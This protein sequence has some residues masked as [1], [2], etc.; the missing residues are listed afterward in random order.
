MT[1][2]DIITLV[3]LVI[4]IIAILNEKN[5]QHLLLKFQFGDYLIFIGAFLLINYFVFYES[6]FNRS[7]YL[8][9]LYFSDFGMGNPKNWA[10][11]IA[12]SSLIYFFYK[13]WF[14][15]YPNIRLSRV[16]KFYHDQ[17]EN[18]EISF[19]LDL[20]ERYHKQDI[21][22]YIDRE[23]DYIPD[24]KWYLHK[25]RKPTN[26]EKL[27]NCKNNIIKIGI[28]S[29]WQNRKIY[30]SYILHDILNDPAL[31][32]LAANH[33]PYLF[34]DFISHF[35]ESKRR[36]FP[37]E[38]TNSFLREIINKNNFWLKKELKQS[39]NFDSGQPDNFFSENRI[40][41]SILKDLSVADVNQVWQPFG[42]IACIEIEE[43]RELGYSSKLYQV[44][45]EEQFLWDYKT[46]YAIYFFKVIVTEA[47]VKKYNKSHF[48]LFYYKNIT[49]AILKTF[50]RYP[51]NDI[52][53]TKTNLHAFIEVMFDNLLFWLHISNNTEDDWFYINIIE[54]LGNIIHYTCNSPHYSEK[55]KIQELDRL[56]E[57]YCNLTTNSHSE[58]IRTQIEKILNKPSMLTETNHPYFSL[59][60]QVW[61]DFDKI[62][63]RLH[64]YGVDHEYFKRLKENVI[65]PLQLDP[66]LY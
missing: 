12:I 32:P 54:C 4:A 60:V 35:K 48:W 44:F 53:N 14:S 28:P 3:S 23:K 11:I 38:F 16:V 22:N 29:S 42:D 15:F 18:N 39:A 25:F 13:V 55:R 17:I 64:G 43:E 6:F 30:A 50:E 19:L 51:P 20:I 31:M 57:F 59:M 45:R 26:K 66:D 65:I 37:D 2:S 1:I 36:T 63:H 21:I 34:A 33:R 5:R 58:N 24:P 8:K 62:P 10:Y 27:I 7:I 41:G 52:E 56:L 40:L 9:Q 61:E 46:F 47:L 49:Q